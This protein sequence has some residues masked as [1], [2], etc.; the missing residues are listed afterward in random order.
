MAL[1][2]FQIA[3]WDISLPFLAAAVLLYLSTMSHEVSI[4]KTRL[5]WGNKSP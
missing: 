3:V 4:A 2:G 1:Y 5:A